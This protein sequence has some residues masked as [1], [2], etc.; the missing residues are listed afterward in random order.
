MKSFTRNPSSIPGLRTDRR[1][2]ALVKKQEGEHQH[3]IA[4]HHKEM[5]ALRDNLNLAQ[6]RCESLSMLREQ[7]LKDFKTYVVCNFGLLKERALSNDTIIV[8][9]RKTIEALHKQLL[10]FHVVYASKMDIEKLHRAVDSL[11]KDS[12][13]GHINTFQDLQREFKILFNSLKDELIKLRSE[14][15]LKIFELTEK[16]ETNFYV[17]RMD[18]D[19]V[20]KELRVYE[21]SMFIIE[22]KIENIYTLIERI[23]KKGE[24]CHKPE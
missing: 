20:L 16:S 8:E 23:N 19:G 18:K 11:V 4:S 7:E 15:E 5:Q 24:I 13:N 10:D 1:F 3:I 12:I 9:Q 14:M 2:D 21:K 6:E 22:K 17:S